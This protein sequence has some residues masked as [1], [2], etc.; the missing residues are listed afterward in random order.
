MSTPGHKGPTNCHISW[1][2]QNLPRCKAWARYKN[3]ALPNSASSFRCPPEHCRQKHCQTSHPGCVGRRLSQEDPTPIQSRM[4]CCKRELTPVRITL[5]RGFRR[6]ASRGLE[7]S[8]AWRLFAVRH[9]GRL[10]L[11]PFGVRAR[12]RRNTPG[13]TRDRHFS[14]NGMREGRR[15]SRAS[16]GLARL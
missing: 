11:D 5:L 14:A 12:V 8:V 3:P 4:Y 7:I 9:V 16:T 15:A 6:S 1:F 13:K 2:P 10:R